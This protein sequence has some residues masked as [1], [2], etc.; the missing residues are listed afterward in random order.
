MS[1][2]KFTPFTHLFEQRKMQGKEKDPKLTS[3]KR[4]EILLHR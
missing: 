1:H 2:I 3:W 4:A